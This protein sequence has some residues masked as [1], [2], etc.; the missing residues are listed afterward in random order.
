[1]SKVNL[2]KTETVKPNVVYTIRKQE[3]LFRKENWWKENKKEYYSNILDDKRF[4]YTFFN[5]DDANR[6]L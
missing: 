3:N 1:M 6:C 2:I 4:I 5:R